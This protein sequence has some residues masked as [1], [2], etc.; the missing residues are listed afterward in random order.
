[1]TMPQRAAT[2]ATRD[3]G[4]DG[5]FARSAFQPTLVDAVETDDLYF[6]R[7]AQEEERAAANA[8]SEATAQIHRNLARKFAALAAAARGRAAK[9][10]GKEESG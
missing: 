3:P 7:R 5:P 8:R 4:R 2:E 1:M 6:A 9:A 10:D